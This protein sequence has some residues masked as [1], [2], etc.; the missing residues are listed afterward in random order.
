MLINPIIKNRDNYAK[1]VI[2][3]FILIYLIRIFS[4]KLLSG[5]YLQP[6]KI[7]ETNYTYWLFLLSKIPQLLTQQY[8]LSLFIDI[9]IPIL[10]I[11]LF[12]KSDN[13][14]LYIIFLI[15]Y[16]IQ[17]ATLE[18]YSG[19]HNKITASLFV[20]FLPLVLNK[21]YFEITLEFARYYLA[22]I[23]VS[24]AY[25]KLHNGAIS[26]DLHYYN[27][28]ILQHI[29]LSIIQPSHISYKIAQFLLTSKTYAY[30][31]FILL[32]IAQISFV[33]VFLTKKIDTFLVLILI[34]FATFT[35]L[36]MRINASDLLILAPTLLY[37]YHNKQ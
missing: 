20:A 3:V 37:A 30:L 19:N 25:H 16:F 21:K 28:L 15:L 9:S 1:S 4:G 22:F 34:L 18:I 17:T 27:T 6:I 8:L 33:L 10:A 29:D 36:I 14:C 11:I 35:Y 23:L 5:I 2:A 13:K 7:Y 31:A 26:N 12:I 32:F 24:A